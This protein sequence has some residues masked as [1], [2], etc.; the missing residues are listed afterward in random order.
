MDGLSLVAL[1]TLREVVRHGSFSAA[2]ESLGYTQSAVSRQVALSE[3]AAGRALFERRARGVE[4]TPAG[5]IVLRHA[6]IA[7]AELE[8]VRLDLEDL[9]RRRRRQVRLGAFSTA[10]AVLVPN[11]LAALRTREPGLDV[12]LR[13]GTSERLIDRVVSGRLDIA[14]VTAS[15]SPPSGVAVERLLDDPL[16]VALPRDHRLAG[17]STV[18]ADELRDE[19]WI[20]GS[21]DPGSTLLGPWTHAS[22]Q[23]QVAFEVRDWT[24]KIGLVASG[25]GITLVPGLSARTLP[26]N[27]VVAALRDPR[28]V[29]PVALARRVGAVD[30]HVAV[31]V[32]ALRD[33]SRTVLSVGRG[34]SLT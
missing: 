6:R 7:L 30:P 20:A 24:A 3:R 16:L 18:S 31:L 2:A 13:E 17:R 29:R 15:A 1:R 26:A 8:A 23:P 11:A 32:G 25:L 9:D 27:V 21:S 10:M 34:P 28:A 19:P 5:E 14:V 22:W 4:L 12:V 33:L